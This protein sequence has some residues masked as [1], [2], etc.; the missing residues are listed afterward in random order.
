MK[1][2][3]RS[4][5]A[6]ATRRADNRKARMTTTSFRVG[7]AISSGSMTSVAAPSTLSPATSPSIC[8]LCSYH[9]LHPLL[10]LIRTWTVS[11]RSH[12]STSSELS[13]LSHLSDP[14]TRPVHGRPSA[15]IR[16]LPLF[17]SRVRST[18][19]STT[20]AFLF[21]RANDAFVK[22]RFRSRLRTHAPC[23]ASM[24]VLK[25]TLMHTY[26]LAHSRDCP[27]ILSR[28]RSMSCPVPLILDARPS[29]HPSI[30]PSFSYSAS[31]SS[32]SCP[33]TSIRNPTHPSTLVVRLSTVRVTR[34]LT[35][36]G[37]YSYRLDAKPRAPQG[38]RPK[39]YFVPLLRP[40]F[41]SRFSAV[42]ICLQRSLNIVILSYLLSRVS[43]HCHLSTQSSS[44]PRKHYATNQL[45]N[46]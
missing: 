3:L 37:H 14:L 35:N 12:N 25:A 1:A 13:P 44:N 30:L 18:P 8:A 31:R 5:P 9:D 29:V 41:S 34:V 43:N 39:T 10:R 26:L 21:E 23:P 42:G 45:V 2:G 19:V 33:P 24:Q 32:H 28:T 6:T 27:G 46:I 4:A 20:A 22:F 38:S 40:S 36:M 16:S 11:F 7:G 15:L 17:L